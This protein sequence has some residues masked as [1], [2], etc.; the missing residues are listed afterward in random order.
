MTQARRHYFDKLIELCLL[1]V[2]RT[3]CAPLDDVVRALAKRR[4]TIFK[5]WVV[6]LHLATY[7]SVH[8]HMYTY[9]YMYDKAKI[10]QN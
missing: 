8:L 9:M 5:L 4:T 6:L 10:Q 7:V 3:I 2:D 1:Y